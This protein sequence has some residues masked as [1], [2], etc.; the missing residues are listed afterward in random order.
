MY[1]IQETPVI[2]SNCILVAFVFEMSQYC[3]FFL[4]KT[5]VPILVKI[6]IHGW[7]KKQ[8]KKGVTQNP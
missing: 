3:L 5:D 4:P 7:C 6:Q 8:Q 2:M 1:Q